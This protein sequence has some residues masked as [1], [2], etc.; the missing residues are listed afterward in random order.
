M[1]H[2]PTRFQRPSNDF[3]RRWPHTPLYPHGVGRGR[4]ALERPAPSDTP[5]AGTTAADV[6]EIGQALI[7]Q[8]AKLGHG[9][10]L[11]WLAA[12]FGMSNPT[13]SRFMNVA[14][15]FGSKSFS[16]KDLDLTALYELAAPSTPEEVRSEVERRIAAGELVTA[17]RD[18]AARLATCMR[19]EKLVRQM[20]QLAHLPS[21]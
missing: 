21:Y 20:C 11:N 4:R 19:G 15:R 7:R 14:E 10:F 1:T 5:Q 18:V 8:K 12:E 3:Q 9:N 17:A 13:A 2:I 6:I 16:V